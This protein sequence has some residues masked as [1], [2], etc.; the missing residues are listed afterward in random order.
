[1]SDSLLTAVS[2]MQA[3][4]L[5]MQAAASNVANAQTPSYQPVA[6]QQTAQSGGGVRAS[7]VKSP[8]TDL[9]AQLVSGIEASTAYRANFAV[10]GA[11]GRAYKSLLDIIA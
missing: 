11:M 5:Q 9:P 7:L 2:G 8:P 1:M 3:A 10:F 6:V 4:S